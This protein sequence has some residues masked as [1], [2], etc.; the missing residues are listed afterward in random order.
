MSW[1]FFFIVLLSACNSRAWFISR[2]AE[3]HHSHG[4]CPLGIVIN[5]SR[6]ALASPES[7]YFGPL[8][9]G[10]SGRGLRP[11]VL[12]ALKGIH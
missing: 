8:E 1:T 12:V 7:T 4:S 9:V 5:G 3:Y 6:N 10:C 2:Y 11:S